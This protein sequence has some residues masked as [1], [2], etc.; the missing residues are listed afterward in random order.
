MVQLRILSG[1]SA[2]AVHECKRFPCQIGRSAAV[3]LRLEDPGVFDRHLQ[4]D[5]VP[6]QGVTATV[7]PGAFVVL[8][9]HALEQGVLRNG[10][11]LDLGAAKV[12]FWLSQTRQRSLRL[13]ETLTWIGFCLL[14]AG[15]ILLIYR[16]LR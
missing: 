9:G 13:R 1:Q 10:D 4:L 15:Q 5:L 7:L 14:C 11:V 2:G 8:N 3:T 16:L 6:G 12:Q